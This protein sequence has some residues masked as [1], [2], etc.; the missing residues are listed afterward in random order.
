V[1]YRR[2]GFEVTTSYD[3]YRVLVRGDLEIH[4]A[5]GEDH[6]PARTAGVAYLRVGDA[7]A[8]YDDLVADLERDGCLYLAPASGVSAAFWEEL[9]RR[10][11]TGIPTV[12]LHEI[13]D[14][15]WGLRQFSV[16]DPSGNAIRVGHLIAAA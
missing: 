5:H 14:E 9:Q 11:E 13:K 7:Q 6:D 12:R 1:F 3:G 8:I 10:Q 15:P 2:L 16:I 4:L